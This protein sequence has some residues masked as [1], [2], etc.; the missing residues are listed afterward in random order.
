M[1]SLTFHIGTRKTGTTFLQHT[2]A[3][4]REVLAEQGVTYPAMTRQP[5][6]TRLVFSF[7]MA[8]TDGA[9]RRAYDVV[10]REA[11]LAEIDAQL[12]Q[13]VEPGSRWLM[14]SETAARL[15]EPEMTQML[16]FL[17]KYFDSIR[18]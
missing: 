5:T 9:R 12:A 15:T 17:G 10:D 2:L 3:G 16:E 18:V 1:A 7:L 14:S 8:N 13:E 4:S 11:A 6:H